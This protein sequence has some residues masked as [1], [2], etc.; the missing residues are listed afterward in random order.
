MDLAD[1]SAKNRKNNS[2]FKRILV[3]IDLEHENAGSR[4]LPAA[5]KLA[6]D[7]DA[8]IALVHVVPTIPGFIAKDIPAGSERRVVENTKRELK[9]LAD[10]Y[11]VPGVVQIYVA[12]GGVYPQIIECASEIKADAILLSSHRPGLSDYL[13][14]SNA[15]RVV[16]HSK[17]SVIVIRD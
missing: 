5:K 6:T 9:A 16:R 8:E 2:M 1:F 4:V 13:L 11:N 17:C 12:Q 14:G 15:A 7:N 3:P 10:K